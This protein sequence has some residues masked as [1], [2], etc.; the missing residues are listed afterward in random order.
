MATKTWSNI[1]CQIKDLMINTFSENKLKKTFKLY[2]PFLWMGFNCLKAEEALR[3][4]SLLFTTSPQKFLVLIWS[5]LE[6]WT[7]ELT[8]EPPSGFEHGTP[9]LLFESL[10]NLRFYCSLCHINMENNQFW[11]L[12]VFYL[13]SFLSCNDCKGVF[14]F[15]YQLSCSKQ[16][17]YW[18]SKKQNKYMH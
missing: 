12:F 17:S 7:A 8:L 1:Q 18:F 6:G 2:G 13:R 9:G 15:D 3:G 14:L 4:N 10:S 5:T 16:C 11:L